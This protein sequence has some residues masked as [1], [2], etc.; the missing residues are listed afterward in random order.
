VNALKPSD[1]QAIAA[2]LLEWPIG[3]G[4]GAAAL[5]GMIVLDLGTMIAGPLAATLLGDF[6]A[7]VIKVE[8]PELGDPMR[9]WSPMKDGESLWWKVIA[10]NKE[11]ITLKLSAPEGRDLLLRLVETADVV[12]ENFRPGTMERWGLGFDD[13]SAINP[14]IVMVR[15]SGYGQDGPYASRPGY[16]TIAEAMSGL[17]AI[18]GFPGQPPTLPPIPLGDSLAAT[19]AAM[20]A[21]FALYARDVGKTGRGQVVDV[22]LYEPLFRLSESLVVGYDQ[23]GIVK[24]RMGNRLA[25]D[26][27]RNAYG[28]SDGEWIAI[29]ASSDRTFVRLAEAIGRG[30][31]AKDERFISNPSR[32]ANADELDAILAEWFAQ[33]PLDECLATLAESDV[34]AGPIYDIERI[35]ADPQYEARKNIVTVEDPTLGR[36]KMQG[37]VP[38]LS[39]TPGGVRFP[40][41]GLGAANDEVFRDRL[42]LTEQQLET[43]RDEGVV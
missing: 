40:G 10:R 34:V 41:L 22:A 36:L 27:P 35:F 3:D 38:K 7:T 23:L 5:D 39:M 37:V 2:G 20:G 19:F 43:L 1:A 25:E 18:M 31:L 16:G 21:M 33:R 30:E 32:I 13:L 9:E 28:T 15:V 24:Q 8:H 29:S 11:L 4:E 12:V 17:P 6:G 14:G 26:S 42:G